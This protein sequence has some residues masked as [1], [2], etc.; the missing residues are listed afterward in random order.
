[1]FVEFFAAL[2]IAAAAMRE[3]PRRSTGLPC[4]CLIEV[5]IGRKAAHIADCLGRLTALQQFFG[6]VDLLH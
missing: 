3:L 4:E 1:M 5:G 6:K 2:R